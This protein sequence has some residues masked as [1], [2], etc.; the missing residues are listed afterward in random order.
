MPGTMS[1]ADLV[2]DLK[3]SLQDAA[4]SFT[5]AADADF[6]RHLDVAAEDMHRVRPRTLVGEI[7]LSAGR[8]DY[9]APADLRR[10]KSAIWGALPDWSKPKPWEKTWPGR[11]PDV[12]VSAGSM[13]LMPAPSLQQI[14]LLGSAFR[15]Y[16]VARDAIG[17]TAA[18]T[19]IQPEDRPLL[20]LRAQAEAMLELS[21]RDSV[22][23]VQTGGGF[24][25]QAKTGM[26]AAIWKELMAAW[27]GAGA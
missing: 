8:A 27:L 23:P 26:P 6:K 5:A 20:L 15:F 21:I 14:A 19:T 13:I 9:T 11:L 25:Q 4:R 3:A 17:D 16:Y 24:G 7:E 22:R 18:E 10:Y 12:R 2:A 1:R